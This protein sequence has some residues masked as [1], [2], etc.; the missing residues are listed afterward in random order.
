MTRDELMEMSV[1]EASHEV[2]WDSIEFLFSPSNILELLLRMN[3]DGMR[4]RV[5]EWISYGTQERLYILD[6]LY[7]R[8]AIQVEEFYR[9]LKQHLQQTK[10]Q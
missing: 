5:E 2:S 9:Q 3:F 7:L 1:E 8:R 6:L 4:I 10:T